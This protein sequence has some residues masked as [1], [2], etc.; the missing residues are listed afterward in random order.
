[1]SASPS[2]ACIQ[3]GTFLSLG[4]PLIAELAAECGFQWLL[5][6]LEHGASTDANLL[7]Q[8]MATKGTA[9]RTIVRFGIPHAD[10]VLRALDWGA[11]GIMIPRVSSAAEAAACVKAASYAPR[12]HRGFSR[13]ARAYG[14]GLRPPTSAGTIPQPLIMAQIENIE[15]VAHA[16]EIAAVEGVDVLFVGPADLQFDLAARPELVPLSYE[17]C[18]VSVASAAQTA[19]KAC[20]IL[21]RDATEIP[22][23]RDLGYTYLALDS[24]V[25]LLRKGFLAL[26]NAKA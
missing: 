14:L 11:H 26:A 15:G 8:L 17:E 5:L 3:L 2:P 9:T 18:L 6:D 22:K 25:A 4:S 1:M 13:S 12:G 10:Q 7:P 19:G 20:G 16:S 24:D 23:F 21:L